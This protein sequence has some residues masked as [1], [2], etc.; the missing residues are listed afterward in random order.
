MLAR[1]DLFMNDRGFY[2][3]HFMTISTRTPEGFPHRCPVCGKTTNLEP[4]FPGGDSCCP[5][6]GHL[7]WWFRNRFHGFIDDETFGLA[8]TLSELG[9]ES[10][11]TVELVMELE[12][13][14]G[15]NIPEES[16]ERFQTIADVIRYIQTAR[17]EKNEE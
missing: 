7:L 14:Y 17:R 16:A 3:R 11:E 15:I 13:E 12:A 2:S 1:H 8:T 4:A 9:A 5:S 6:C 10:L